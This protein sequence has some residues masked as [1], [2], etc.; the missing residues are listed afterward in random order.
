MGDVA[1]LVSKLE[2]NEGKNGKARENNYSK[3]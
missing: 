1:K 2:T 3:K